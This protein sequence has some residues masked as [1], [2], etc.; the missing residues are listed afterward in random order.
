VPTPER[1]A[2]AA[3]ARLNLD[4]PKPETLPGRGCSSQ[5]GAALSAG[6]SH[7]DLPRQEALQ[8]GASVSFGLKARRFWLSF[9][10]LLAMLTVSPLF[11]NPDNDYKTAPDLINTFAE[12]FGGTT[13][14]FVVLGDRA[15]LKPA[16]YMRDRAARA[17]FVVQSL[18]AV[19]NRSQGGVRELLRQRGVGFT[20][21]WVENKIYIRKGTLDL[22]QELA[23]RPEVVA[24]LPEAI[25]QIPQPPAEIQKSPQAVEWN[26]AQIGADQVWSTWGIHGEKIVVA[27]NDTG[28]QYTHPAVVGKYRGNTGS[29]FSH[30]GNWKDPASI[31]GG[32][33]CDNMGHGTHTM[34]TMVGDDGAGNQVGVAPG[35]KWIACKGCETNSCSGSSLISCAQWF[36]DPYGDGKGSGQP[37]VVNNSWGGGSGSPWYESYIQSWRA[38]A[39][40]PAFS[41]ANSGSGC[42]TANS[43]GDNPEAFA[44]GASGQNDVIASFSSRGPSAFGGA[45]KPNV[46]APGVSVRSSVPTNSYA[47][48]SGTSMASPHSAGMVALIWW[49]AAPSYRGN[50]AATEPL[51]ETTAA[52]LYT[53]QGCWGDSSSSHPNNTY[54]WGRIDALAAV[55]AATGAPPPNQPPTVT[56]TAPANGASFLCP[57]TVDFTATASDPDKDLTDPV[58]WTDN[59]T[60][61]A[62][63]SSAQKSYQCTD[64]G[65]HNITAKV[66]DAGGLSDTDTI[67]IAITNLSPP[68][69]PSKLSAS[70]QRATVALNWRD[71]SSNETGFQV[72]RAPKGGAWTLVKT[73]GEGVRT[74][75]DSPGTG[76][77]Q[78]RVRSYNAAGSSAASNIA[79][80]RVK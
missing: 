5:F 22:A 23:Q 34:G 78:Y 48:Y 33:P 51:L 4:W 31:C 30:D 40:F 26:I 19:A 45:I 75:T 36:L 44:S 56:I 80:A 63:G 13:P 32:V 9:A 41:A 21:F 61:F 68:V 64:V 57:A 35:A 7:S 50:I 62:S 25:Y 37:D 73:V 14:F 1:L 74:T 76:N 49:A 69:A 79:T 70:V 66:T 58:S 15:N 77:W 18:Q 60:A 71:N 27:N 24:I 38:A 67:T 47:Y 59:G 20:A 65:P 29:S 52:E 10:F 43:P 54:G 16:H 72:E 3:G 17:K 28:V 2:S 46:S 53:S 8:A 11:G 42:G 6:E 12:S 39:I 55:N